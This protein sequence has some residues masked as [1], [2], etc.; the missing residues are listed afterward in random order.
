MIRL[1]LLFIKKDLRENIRENDYG[2]NEEMEIFDERSYTVISIF[3]PMGVNVSFYCFP[4]RGF[5]LEDFLY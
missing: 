4:I 3:Y 2:Y 5:N 1:K